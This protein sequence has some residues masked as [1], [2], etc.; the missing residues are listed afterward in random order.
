ML[1]REPWS[2]FEKRLCRQLLCRQVPELLEL[3][4]FIII[5][6]MR[7]DLAS[8]YLWN[9]FDIIFHQWFI[10]LFHIYLKLRSQEGQDNFWGRINFYTVW[11]EEG[12]KNYGWVR[13][14]LKWGD[15]SVRFLAYLFIIYSYSDALSMS[16][17]HDE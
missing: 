7:H 16:Q 3:S 13:N 6:Q 2:R 4:L 9:L 8:E 17:K 11:K 1:G 14:K 10:E 15:R 5:S 12:R